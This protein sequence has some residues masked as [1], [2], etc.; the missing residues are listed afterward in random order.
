MK[1]DVSHK[2]ELTGNITLKARREGSSRTFMDAIYLRNTGELYVSAYQVE[3]SLRGRYYSVVLFN[4]VIAAAAKH[5]K[6]DVVRGSA[7][8]SNAQALTA[9]DGKVDESRIALTPWAKALL[10]LGYDS[11]FEEGLMTSCHVGKESS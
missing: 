10:R 8:A 9:A 6:V 7:R 3:E 2:L 4:E 11:R 5:G 1:V